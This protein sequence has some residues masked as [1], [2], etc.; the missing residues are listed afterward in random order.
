MCYCLR[1]YENLNA[2][3]L[4]VVKYFSI[5]LMVVLVTLRICVHLLPLFMLELQKVLPVHFW[6]KKLTLHAN[7]GQTQMVHR[8]RHS[9]K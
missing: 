3:P 1:T 2:G 6:I 4:L 8:P 9:Q 7:G 5:V